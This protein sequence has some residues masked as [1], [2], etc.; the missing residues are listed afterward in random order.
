[1]DRPA[2]NVNPI[3]DGGAPVSF[4]GLNQASEFCARAQ[5]SLNLRPPRVVRELGFGPEALQGGQTIAQWECSVDDLHGNTAVFVFDVISGSSPML[6]G[7]DYDQSANTVSIDPPARW[8]VRI[9]ETVYE[10]S[11]VIQRDSDGNLR[12]FV[13]FISSPSSVVAML[14]SRAR[15]KQG[16]V[17]FALEDPKRFALK[18]HGWSHYSLAQMRK[19]ARR[20]DVLSPELDDELAKVVE[21]CDVCPLT[22]SNVGSRGLRRVSLSKVLDPM[23]N[24]CVE[25]DHVSHVV[26][27]KPTVRETLCLAMVC[28]T[29]GF[30]ETT[31]V[32]SKSLPVAVASFELIW[33]CRHGAPQIL[34]ADPGLAGSVMSAFCATHSITWQTRPPR[35]HNTIGVVERRNGVMRMVL[36]KLVCGN[37]SVGVASR[38]SDEV[39]L[40]RANFLAN[41]YVGNVLLSSFELFRGYMPSL[42]GMPSRFVSDADVETHVQLTA[43]RAISRM[44]HSKSF[45]PYV[46]PLL[47]VGQLVYA[48]EQCSYSEQAW[49]CPRFYR[50][51]KAYCFQIGPRVRLYSP[52]RSH[53]WQDE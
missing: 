10:F 38:A 26:S 12:R 39:L 46:K 2:P 19:L 41:L 37:D 8:C 3:L 18:L 11:I 53:F 49:F 20:A 24:K 32:A 36:E 33:V 52:C 7:L 31:Q 6:L 42:V 25:L 30:G 16:A 9:G 29:T 22:G 51:G 4:V 17:R 35:R 13:E 28:Q 47:S 43:T 21:R 1:M 34:T 14:G 50:M 48:I 45:N 44:L 23:A 5:M 27:M 40:E 15:R